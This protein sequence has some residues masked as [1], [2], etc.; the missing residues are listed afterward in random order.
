MVHLRA[1]KSYQNS[2]IYNKL[3]D[4]LF[5]DHHFI[6]N[7]LVTGMSGKIRALVLLSFTQCKAKKGLRVKENLNWKTSKGFIVTKQII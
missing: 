4:S 1:K 6:I 3:I 5:P 2:N 7:I